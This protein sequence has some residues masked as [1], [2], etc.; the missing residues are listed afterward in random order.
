[1]SIKKSSEDCPR[2]FTKISSIRESLS[3][4]LAHYFSILSGA[5][6]DVGLYDKVIAE[7]EY[8]LISETLKYTANNQL[9]AS[10]ILGI[11]R[12]TLR[13]KLQNH[14]NHENNIQ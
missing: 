13:K 10:A 4:I 14:L 5:D 12:N 1:M 8:V 6:P 11:N 9:K 7:V 2:D 3:E